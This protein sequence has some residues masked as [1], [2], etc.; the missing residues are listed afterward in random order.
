MKEKHNSTNCDWFLVLSFVKLE[1]MVV[2]F[3]IFCFSSG[4]DGNLTTTIKNQIKSISGKTLIF[5][6]YSLSLVYYVH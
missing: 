4:Y 2:V 6:M 5:H 3:D 1:S